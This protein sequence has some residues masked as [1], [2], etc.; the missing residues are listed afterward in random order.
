M[1]DTAQVVRAFDDGGHARRRHDAYER[2]ALTHERA[3]TFHLV[4]HDFFAQHG[5]QVS[6]EREQRLAD[7][8]SV[9]AELDHARAVRVLRLQVPASPRLGR[10]GTS[11]RGGR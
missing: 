11:G 5:D 2:A 6:V 10:H 3:A 7:E 9:A 4:A 8:E 1:W